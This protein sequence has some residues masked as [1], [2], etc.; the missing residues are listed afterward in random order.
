M[1]GIE[2]EA[3][4]LWRSFFTSF[5]KLKGLMMYLEILLQFISPD[6]NTAIQALVI[7]ILGCSLVY[8][9]TGL[10]VAKVHGHSISDGAR[11]RFEAAA[12]FMLIGAA[13]K[14]ALQVK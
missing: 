7:S 14:L 13:I 9:V 3:I 8:S 1:H 2:E 10:F 4:S 6:C 11:R 5:L 12:G